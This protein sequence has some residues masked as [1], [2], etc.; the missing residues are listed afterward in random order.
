MDK[1][2]LVI[3]LALERMGGLTPVQLARFLFDPGT[4]EQFDLIGTLTG[5]K[6]A[7]LLEQQ[8]TQSGI[9][10][11]LTN[12]GGRTLAP[13]TAALPAAELRELQ[14]RS[15][16]Y[17]RMFER[18]KDYIAQY[19]EQANAI[20]PI[21]LSI[22]DGGKILLKVSVIVNDIDTAKRITGNWMRNAHKTY[23]AVWE[24]IA[25]GLPRPEFK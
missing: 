24:S 18:E 4:I 17:S 1:Q 3:L 10:Y 13:H 19:T 9:A 12:K 23:D 11:S 20:V 7:G 2:E 22:R 5:L 21:F 16:E 25:E 15:A 6:D 14:R 8:V